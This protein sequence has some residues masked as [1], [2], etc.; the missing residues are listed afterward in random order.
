MLT[1]KTTTIIFIL[2]LAVLTGLDITY[3]I[4]FF[5]YAGL[6]IVYTLFL[7]YGSAYIN[8]NFYFKVV[9][10]GKTDKKEIAISFDDGPV[11]EYTPAILKTLRQYD[12]KAAFFCIGKR[13]QVN[14]EL[15][16]QA[17][18]E[19]HII[20]NHSYS[21]STV[22]DLFSAKKMTDD[23]QQMS[24][25]ARHTLGVELKWFRPP[26]GVT[27]PNLKKAVMN[28][29]FTAIGW[30][31][32]SLDT[33]IRDKDKLLQKVMKALKPG[34]IILFHDTCKPTSDM[35]SEFIEKVKASGYTIVPM[36]KLLNLQ[37]Y[38]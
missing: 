25:V 9:C 23:L 36:D 31:I 5:F 1:F 28:G 18:E 15:F 17:Y 35:L 3:E 24:E 37:P 4:S 22:F 10:E 27:N 7:F 13:A 19:G 20:G 33:T 32:R 16:I 2:L 14:K 30:N 11:S 38:A 34:A 21:H 12:V 26:Y 8:S 6:I 29:N